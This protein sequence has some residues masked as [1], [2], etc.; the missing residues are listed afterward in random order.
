[1][2]RDYGKEI[3]SL[4]EQIKSLQSMTSSHGTSISSYEAPAGR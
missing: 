4:R 1:M 3:D 2:E